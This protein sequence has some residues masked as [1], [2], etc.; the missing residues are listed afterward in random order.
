MAQVQDIEGNVEL[1]VN[2]NMISKNRRSNGSA[3]VEEVKVDDEANGNENVQVEAEVREATQ[4][5]A[6]EEVEV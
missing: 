2:G 5:N 3:D 6:E 4:A 1:E